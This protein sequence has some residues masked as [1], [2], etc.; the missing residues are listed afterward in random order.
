MI[1]PLFILAG[2]AAVPAAAQVRFQDTTAIDVAVAAFTGQAAGTQ[3]GARAPVD[4]RLKLAACPLP[5]LD[6]RSGYQDAVVVTCDSPRWRIYVPI[7]L[8]PGTAQTPVRRPR[9]PD[10]RRGR[11][12]RLLDHPRRRGDGRRPRRRAAAGQGRPRQAADP[13]GCGRNRPRD[14]ARLAL[15]RNDLRNVVLRRRPEPW[16]S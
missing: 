6:W 1:R 10:H 14:A 5:Q 3:G 2:L 12:G 4:P 9:R 15:T 7:K 8:A 16:P 11:R 13:G